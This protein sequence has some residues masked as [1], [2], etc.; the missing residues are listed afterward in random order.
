MQDRRLLLRDSS[1]SRVVRRPI[2]LIT[3]DTAA[4]GMCMGDTRHR[5][6]AIRHIVVKLICLIVFVLSSSLVS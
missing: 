1:Y 4:M 6:V 3:E 5:L 2:S